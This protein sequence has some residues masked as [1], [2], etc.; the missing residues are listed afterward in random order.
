MHALEME[1]AAYVNGVSTKHAPIQN[2]QYR[3]SVRTGICIAALEGITMPN[4]IK[5][6]SMM[7]RKTRCNPLPTGSGGYRSHPGQPYACGPQPSIVSAF[8]HTRLIIPFP[9]AILAS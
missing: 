8:C 2:V 5:N 3:F 4:E 1:A 9:C 6:R 7:K